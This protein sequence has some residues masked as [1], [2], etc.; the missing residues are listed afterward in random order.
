MS[1]LKLRFLKIIA[2]I[3]RLILISIQLI[4]LSFGCWRHQYIVVLLLQVH[5]LVLSSGS[6][7]HLCNHVS[8]NPLQSGSKPLWLLV[9]WFPKYVVVFVRWG[10][11]MFFELGFVVFWYLILGLANQT[12]YGPGDTASWFQSIMF[13]DEGQVFIATNL[14]LFF[15]DLLFFLH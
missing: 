8:T 9:E 13:V 10:H 11:W 3:Q 12:L 6:S 15:L 4:T 1:A 14:K 5:A 2:F 7:A